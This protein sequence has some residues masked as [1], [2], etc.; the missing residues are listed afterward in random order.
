MGA[1]PGGPLD[2]IGGRGAALQAQRTDRTHKGLSEQLDEDDGKIKPVQLLLYKRT[3]YDD[4]AAS[5]LPH[6]EDWEISRQ[7]VRPQPSKT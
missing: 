1:G 5:Q 2:P 3:F 7:N 6:L 4:K